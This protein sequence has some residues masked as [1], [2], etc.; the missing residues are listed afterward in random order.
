MLE[1]L[2]D[3][4]ARSPSIVKQRSL[5]RQYEKRALSDMAHIA[6]TRGGTRSILTDLMLKAGRL[7]LAITLTSSWITSGW[8]NKQPF[9][10]PR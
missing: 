1:D 7:L 8:I 10:S 2:Y 5:I 9:A 4:I 6:I 3:R